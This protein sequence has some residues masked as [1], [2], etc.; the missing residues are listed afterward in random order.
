LDLELSEVQL[1]ALKEVG[2]IGSGNAAT[3][4]SQLLCKN[5]QMG[6]PQIDILQFPDLI[7]KLGNEEDAFVGVLLKVYGDTPGNILFL[8]DVNR[9]REISKILLSNEYN[10]DSELGLSMFQEMGNILGNSYINAIS[11]LTKLNL[12]TSVPAVCI[13]MLSA[14]L[15]ASFMEAEQYS[16]Y[17]LAIDTSYHEGSS[18]L[19]VHKS[20][21][22]FLLI[23]KPGSLQTILSNLGL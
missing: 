22:T 8:L 4:L 14:L 2:N 21:G 12:V 11:M 3:A 19:N 1:D 16:D 6:I 5:I 7:R 17:V 23:P 9:A 18:N 15:S 13:D 10:F 20:G